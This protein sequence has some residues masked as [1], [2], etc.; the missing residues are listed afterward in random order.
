M[1]VRILASIMAALALGAEPAAAADRTVLAARDRFS[2]GNVVFELGQALDQA[3]PAARL[4]MEMDVVSAG[5]GADGAPLGGASRLGVLGKWADG[6]W[7][8]RLF[9]LIHGNGVFVPSGPDDYELRTLNGALTLGGELAF[10]AFGLGFVYAFEG[11]CATYRSTGEGGLPDCPESATRHWVA[12]RP[13]FPGLRLTAQL[14]AALGGPPSPDLKLGHRLRSAPARDGWAFLDPI[15]LYEVFGLFDD[16]G[17]HYLRFE[18]PGLFFDDDGRRTIAMPVELRIGAPA[19]EGSYA[20]VGFSWLEPTEQKLSV[21]VNGQRRETKL[22]GV[23]GFT[24]GASVFVQPS[25][26]GPRLAPGGLL[27]YDVLG[28]RTIDVGGFAIELRWNHVDDLWL[29]PTTENLLILA[30]H[31]TLPLGLLSSS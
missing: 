30:V 6:S 23:G 20:F 27:R 17:R 3:R 28:S 12:V 16:G 26:A 19:L 1:Q 10:R 18:D 25:P 2:L 9:S 22:P 14:G 24:V 29:A 13:I 4:L 21:T 15:A 5:P 7:D 11:Y 8:L 31:W